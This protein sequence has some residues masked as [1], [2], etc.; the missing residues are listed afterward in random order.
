M[1]K[2]LSHLGEGPF[3]GRAGVIRTRD[4][5]N[6]IQV[7][8]QAAL[9]P[10]LVAARTAATKQSTPR[11]RLASNVVLAVSPFATTAR[12]RMERCLSLSL[13]EVWW[14]R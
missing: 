14:P 10:A 5:L 1:K 13:Y 7:R 6:P 4:H 11:Y 3:A 8:Y 9:R 12:P 2:P